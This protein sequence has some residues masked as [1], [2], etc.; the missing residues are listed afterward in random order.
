MKE[1]KDCSFSE[2]EKAGGKMLI[3]AQIDNCR[4]APQ[5]PPKRSSHISGATA[6]YSN[7]KP[8]LARDILLPIH[9]WAAL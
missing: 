8:P 6:G 7:N 3:S 5:V 9:G 4:I 2:Q 1:A